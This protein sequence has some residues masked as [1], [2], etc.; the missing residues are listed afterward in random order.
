MK[1]Q[2]FRLFHRLR[3]R[4]AEVDLQKIVFNAHYLMYLDTALGDYWRALALPYEQ[5][6][7]SLGGDLYVKKATLE[8]HASARGEDQLDI[9]FKCSRIGNSSLN[10]VAGI[11]RAEQLL[12]AGEM[13]YVFAD[14][15]SQSARPVPQALRDVIEGYEAGSP[16]LRLDTGDWGALGEPSSRL[17]RD[18]FVEEQGIPETLVSDPLDAAAIHAVAFNRLD[19]PV[20]AGRMVQREPG[21]SQVGRL[22]VHRVLRGAGLGQQVLERLAQA[23]KQRG[24]RELMLF[25]QASA[26]GFYLRQ[27]FSPRGDPFHEVGIEHI[28]MVRTLA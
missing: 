16:M 19:L 4:W 13:V 12:V 18:V 28:E 10:F 17:R 21:V 6:L 3:V 24:D 15:V 20:A 7:A 14:P 11:F 22:A 25:A 23:A 5:S 26:R 9:G 27:G 1:R 2:D 8:Y